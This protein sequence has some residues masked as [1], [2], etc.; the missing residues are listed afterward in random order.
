MNELAVIPPATI[1]PKPTRAEIIDAMTNI[2][3]EQLKAEQ[4]KGLAEREK[5]QKK[6]EAMIRREALKNAKTLNANIDTGYVRI[7][8]GLKVIYSVEY[9]LQ[10]NQPSEE[11][12]AAIIR[13]KELPTYA[14]P[15]YFEDVRKQVLQASKLMGESKDSRIKK[16]CTD[17]KSRKALEAA[18]KEII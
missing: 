4:E 5:L 14:R 16:L 2:R 18:L 1:Q 10:I 12:R 15:F 8:D 17:P 11:L 3:I 7:I 13:L 6:V 9:R